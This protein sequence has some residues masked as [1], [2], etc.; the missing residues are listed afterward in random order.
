MSRV[1]A[2][3]ALWRLAP[4]TGRKPGWT[5]APR[6]GRSPWTD[7]PSRG[8]CTSSGHCGSHRRGAEATD[9]RPQPATLPLLQSRWEGGGQ[10]S[11][12]R[13]ADDSSLA[14]SPEP[15]VPR[16]TLQGPCAQV[17]LATK[18]PTV[19]GKIPIPSQPLLASPPK[20][21][22][23]EQQPRAPPRDPQ[24]WG[25]HI[26]PVP[27]PEPR[28]QRKATCHEGGRYL[29]KQLGGAA[30]HIKIPLHW[31]GRSQTL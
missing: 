14:P 1:P 11:R 24:L 10:G 2:G 16:S 15:P 12:D 23:P 6:W 5:P 7:P 9:L 17:G 31:L 13:E 30:F 4:V 27:E 19:G 18:A 3:G 28:T 8:W 20:T 21:E 26:W 25:R 22:G 29:G